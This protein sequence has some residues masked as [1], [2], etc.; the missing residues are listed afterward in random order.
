MVLAAS[1]DTGNKKRDKKMHASVLLSDSH[2]EI[3]F[4]AH[5][6]EGE[7]DA[8]GSS[9]ITLVGVM[10]ILGVEHPL[11]VPVEVDT[12]DGT[13]RASF[14]VPYVDWGLEDPSTFVLRV[15]K[16]V[17]VTVTARITVVSDT[18]AP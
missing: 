12:A 18:G 8:S 11:T 3:R 2:P 17:P 14:T 1:A 6:Y 10:E 15:G 9:E 4:T 13:A 7:I 5:R 16:E